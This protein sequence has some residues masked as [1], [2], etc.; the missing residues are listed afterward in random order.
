MDTEVSVFSPFD[1]EVGQK[2]QISDG[3][4]KGD[5]QVVGCDERKVT[6]RCPVSSREFSWD[7]FCYLVETRQQQWPEKD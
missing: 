6:L 4:R 5:W 3:P 7:R 1:F 2:I